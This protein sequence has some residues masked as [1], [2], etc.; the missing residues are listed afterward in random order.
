MS[1]KFNRCR[2]AQLHKSLVTVMT[3]SVRSGGSGGGGLLRLIY[4]SEPASTSTELSGAARPVDRGSADRRIPTERR[5]I[6]P[7]GL[8]VRTIVRCVCV[9]SSAACAYDRAAADRPGA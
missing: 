3:G 2:L 6:D 1:Q 8:R 7:A 4:V 5:A 9:L